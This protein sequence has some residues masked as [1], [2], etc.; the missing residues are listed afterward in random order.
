MPDDKRV[1]MMLKLLYNK[2]HTNGS[3]FSIEKVIM[4]SDVLPEMMQKNFKESENP[5]E[6]ADEWKIFF[7]NIFA[8]HQLI[9]PR[10]DPKH[11]SS[12]AFIKGYFTTQ[13]TMPPE[14]NSLV[15]KYNNNY[16]GNYTT[17]ND[18]NNIYRTRNL[19]LRNL[20]S[21][22]SSN[23]S[24]QF[25][26]R[27]INTFFNV[28][29]NNGDKINE[30]DVSDSKSWVNARHM[31]IKENA[32]T[33][34]EGVMRDTFYIFKTKIEVTDNEY[35]YK[36]FNFN[37]G[38]LAS[39]ILRSD[40]KESDVG[41]SSMLLSKDVPDEQ[42]HRDINNNLVESSTG[43]QVGFS[44]QFNNIKKGFCKNILSDNLKPRECQL[45]LMDCLNGKNINACKAYFEKTDFWLES[46]KEVDD[47]DP[48]LAL[49]TLRAFQFKAIIQH[50]QRVNRPLKKV[51]GY[52]DWIRTLGFL[53][54]EGG[55][56]SDD[57]VKIQKNH[58]LGI[59]LELLTIKVNA[60]PTLLN[61]DYKGESAE[62]MEG[63]PTLLLNTRFGKF[64]MKQLP[65]NITSSLPRL[66][67]SLRFTMVRGIT[68]IMIGGAPFEQLETKIKTGK[69]A[70]NPLR[71]EYSSLQMSLRNAN[72]SISKNDSDAIEKLFKQLQS[73]E[74]KL[75]KMILYI[76]KYYNLITTQ[77]QSDH[78]TILSGDHIKDFVDKREHLLKRVGKRQSNILSILE[79]IAESLTGVRPRSESTLLRE[80][81]RI[82]PFINTEETKDYLPL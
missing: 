22:I 2:F 18:Y 47:M 8:Y 5:N 11:G 67:D 44:T 82:N 74:E 76:E 6:L 59:Y 20:E 50:D 17:A 72:K 14:W 4:N 37:L 73:S 60:S 54:E 15:S 19:L 28:Y 43:M 3:T 9:A 79:S 71:L 75:N 7:S 25:I 70:Y 1:D 80:S 30:T 68:P 24:Y 29:N 23:N 12:S 52:S 36:S 78:N 65:G 45:Y 62:Q 26:K 35:K 40:R 21:D 42:Y 55:L 33:P 56:T 41:V 10:H 81:P 51:I 13:P 64:G 46:Q 38:K 77:Q 32:F 53:V 63:V 39:H 61:P 16:G 66:R 34:L 58:K 69:Y 48:E 49:S 27:M 31:S 57:L